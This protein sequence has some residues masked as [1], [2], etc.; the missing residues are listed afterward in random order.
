MPSCKIYDIHVSE[1][2]QCWES[3][4]IVFLRPRLS[5]QEWV[6]TQSPKP[7]QRGQILQTRCGLRSFCEKQNCSQDIYPTLVTFCFHWTAWIVTSLL[8]GFWD[9]TAQGICAWEKCKCKKSVASH[10][11]N[12]CPSFPFL[13]RLS[14]LLFYSMSW[15]I[16]PPHKEM[17][18]N[19][20]IRRY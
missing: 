20:E 3:W 4:K 2:S 5:G 14:D 10:L 6:L 13:S 1:K 19:P 11:A 15:L 17:D 18:K 16:V 9:T 7:L 8:W 12:C